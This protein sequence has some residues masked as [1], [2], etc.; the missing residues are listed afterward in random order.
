[1]AYSDYTLKD[2]EKKLGVTQVR[3]KLF[4]HQNIAP[5]QPSTSLIETLEI[6]KSLPNS[7][8]EKA[9]S[10]N[11]IAPVLKE[12]YK[13][14]LLKLNIFSGY[15]FDIDKERGL[16]GF[17]DYLLT[18][19]PNTDLITAPVFCIAEAKHRS[20]GEAVP[21]VG[22]EM[23]AARFFNEKEQKPTPT[24]YGCATNGFEWLFVIL[25]KNTLLTDQ[26]PYYLNDSDLPKIL[27]IFQ[28][29][30]HKF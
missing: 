5:I 1:M 24:V 30:F 2:L 25:D 3:Q 17:C 8:S 7:P 26:A 15:Q 21:Q 22:A 10:E 13:N 20:V 29:I 14:A 12:V 16:N 23:F 19:T 28:H 4:A 18:T 9:T 11:L 6:G 27:G